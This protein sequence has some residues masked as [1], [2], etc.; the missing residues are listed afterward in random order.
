MS[1]SLQLGRFAGIKVQIHWT[2]W[3][4]FVFIGFAVFAND[5]SV[6]DVIWNFLFIFALF[7]C[8]VL[9][10]FG[11]A[12]AARRFGVGTRSITLLPIGGVANLQDIPDNPKEE[13]IIAIAGPLVNVVIAMLLYLVVPLDT[14]LVD[15]PE[16]LEEQLSSVNA[17]NFLFYLLMVNIALVVFNMIPAFPMDG[18]RVFR[19]ALSTKMSR[20]DAT[21]AATALGKF[22]AFVFFLVGLFSNIIL[23]VIAVFIYFGAHSENIM[24]QQISLLQGNDI[25]DAMIT[26]YTLLKPDETLQHAVDRILASTEQ[27]FI[28][29][30]NGSPVGILYMSD[31]AGALKERDR[32]SPVSDI[33][34]KNFTTL[35]AGDPLPS[36]YR[37]IQRGSKNFFPVVENGN[38]VGVLDM[39]NI[40]E[41]LTFRAAHDY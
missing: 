27:D 10:E 1:A 41:F 13:F 30:E 31:L 3:L 5:G 40:N 33:M 14:F 8:V 15:D 32:Q 12:L 18:G 29:A 24:I 2:F 34:N 28:V 6:Q 4:L 35:N 11:H 26:D 23:A 19:A 20:V 7:F 17:S 37:Q 9:H 25:R 16:M 21:K 39:N 36:V 38:I 22:L